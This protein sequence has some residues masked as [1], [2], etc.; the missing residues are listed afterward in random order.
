MTADTAENPWD[1]L[2]EMLSEDTPE[3]FLGDFTGQFSLEEKRN[4]QAIYTMKYEA[5]GVTGMETFEVHAEEMVECYCNGQLADV[6]L[7]SPYKLRVGKFLQEGMN[8]LK[9][10]VVGNAANIYSGADI[11]FGLRHADKV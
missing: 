11:P 7:W 1:L 5:G 10:V 4:N 9:L 8:E 2:Q 6:A 3:T